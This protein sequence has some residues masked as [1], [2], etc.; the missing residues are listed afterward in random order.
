MSHSASGELSA[1]TVI[2]LIESGAY[3]RDVVATI[4]RGFLP[5]DQHDLIAVLAF[6]AGSD[7][8]EIAALARASLDDTP[9]RV[10]LDLAAGDSLDPAHLRRLMNVHDDSM[11]LEAL[12]RNPRV[13]DEAV[14]ELARRADSHVQEVIVI[15]QARILRT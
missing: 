15:N 8:G 5:L 11:V 14:A 9:A 7:D 10:L 4:A 13:P 2:G 12:V 6:L 1:A 3:P